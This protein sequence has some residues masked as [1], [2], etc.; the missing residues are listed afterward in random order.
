MKQYN[1]SIKGKLLSYFKQRLRIKPS[2][3]GYWRCDCKL[4]G[5]TYSMGINLDNSKVL[6]FKCGERLSPVKLLMFLENFTLINQAYKFL[7]IQQEYEYYESNSRLIRKY[8]AVKLP[9]GFRSLMDGNDLI[10]RAA[11]HYMRK[12]G[13]NI[14]ELSLKGVGYC[15]KGEY[16]GYII[17]PFYIK[18][19]LVYFQG[20]IFMGDGP[21]MKNPPDEAFGI[22]KSQVIFNQDALYIYTRA[23]IVESITNAL[24]LGD[25]GAAIQGKTISNNQMSSIIFSPCEKAVIILD[26]D[27]YKEAVEMAMGIVNYKKVKVVKLPDQMKIEGKMRDVDVNAIGKKKTL[28]FVK[29]HE[30]KRYM[31]LFRL[32]LNL[33]GKTTEHTRNGRGPNYIDKRGL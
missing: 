17:F 18:G 14:E 25:A 9:D 4:C 1:K 24:T 28:E 12:R 20:R 7:S 5:G 21:K 3:K 31:E 33:N 19:E 15:I 23:F 13:F 10:G 26:P 27:A 32:K 22:G 30:Y 6:C 8:K 16:F 29:A 11:R 2:T